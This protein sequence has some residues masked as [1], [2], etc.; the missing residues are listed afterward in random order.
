MKSKTDD[1][2]QKHADRGNPVLS[3]DAIKLLK[4]QDAGYLK[5][6]AQ[7]TRKARERSEHGFILCEGTGAEVL[8]VHLDQEH[9]HHVIFT[10]NRDEQ[11]R[12]GPENYFTVTEDGLDWRFNH[13]MIGH[14]KH[15]KGAENERDKMPGSQGKIDDW[16]ARRIDIRE[17]LTLKVSRSLRK[18][19]RREQEAR[20]SNLKALKTR[21][22]NLMAAEQALDL[23][24]AKMSN[25]TGGVTKTGMK[26]KIRERKR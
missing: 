19:H 22:N 1:K 10:E 7:K 18:H 9:Q 11:K 24:R 13:P 2:G 5:T 25:S 16:K 6:M 3:Q 26:W 15:P 21:E 20:K 14:I 8:G 17:A 23:Q 4:T 12:L